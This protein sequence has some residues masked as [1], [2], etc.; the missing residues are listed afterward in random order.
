[1]YESERER[2]GRDG[3]EREREQGRGRG[4]GRGRERDHMRLM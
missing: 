4:R 2:G 1:V 3:I